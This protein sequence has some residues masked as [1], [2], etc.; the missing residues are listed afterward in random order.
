MFNI[1]KKEIKNMKLIFIVQAY[2]EEMPGM[3]LSNVCTV[4]LYCK[5]AE[6]A[7]KRAKS[8]IKKKFYRISQVIEK[9]T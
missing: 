5:S 6:E 3:Q 1:Y 2:E 7:L 9:E 8:I 4:E